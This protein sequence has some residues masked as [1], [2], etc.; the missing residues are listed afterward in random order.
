ML[1]VVLPTAFNCDS[2]SILQF[3]RKIYDIFQPCTEI[4]TSTDI[5]TIISKTHSSDEHWFNFICKSIFQ[6][7]ILTDEYFLS[8]SCPYRYIV[9]KLK[10][11][12]NVVRRWL[13]VWRWD[14]KT[15]GA[16]VV[17]DSRLANWQQSPFTTSLLLLH[18]RALA[19]WIRLLFVGEWISSTN[20]AVAG[21][22]PQ[23]SPI[24]SVVLIT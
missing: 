6:V 4:A 2:L 10:S 24:T 16:E 12:W 20:Y 18:F 3:T 14:Y 17:A 23:Q 19:L 7:N 11:Y 21:L 1:L 13:F 9:S 8:L 15:T 5:G 22:N